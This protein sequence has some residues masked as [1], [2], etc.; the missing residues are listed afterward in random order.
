M[1]DYSHYTLSIAAQSVRTLNASSNVTAFGM[2]FAPILSSLFTI[3]E[4]MTKAC[5]NWTHKSTPQGNMYRTHTEPGV[6][7]PG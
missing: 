1:S 2:S 6:I 4:G 5:C 3:A 7:M